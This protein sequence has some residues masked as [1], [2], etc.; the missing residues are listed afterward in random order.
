MEFPFTTIIYT[1]PPNEC[2]LLLFVF[3]GLFW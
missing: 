2:V 3:L 1:S